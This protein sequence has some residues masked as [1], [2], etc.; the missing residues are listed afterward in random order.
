MPPEVWNL[1]FLDLIHKA[2]FL[3]WSSFM[4]KVYFV[5]FNW[6]T[7]KLMTRSNLLLTIWSNLLYLTFIRLHRYSVLLI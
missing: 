2:S 5:L 7:S 1:L 3:L 6:K 4:L